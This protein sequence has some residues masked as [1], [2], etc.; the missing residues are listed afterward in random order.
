MQSPTRIQDEALVKDNVPGIKYA[1][2]FEPSAGEIDFNFQL[3]I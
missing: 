1:V 3:H 2:N